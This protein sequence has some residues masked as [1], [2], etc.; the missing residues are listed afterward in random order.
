MK[1]SWTPKSSNIAA[2][3]CTD[4]IKKDI[5]GNALRYKTGLFT[6][7]TN[8]VLIPKGVGFSCRSADCLYYKI[9]SG[10][11][12]HLI[13]YIDDLLSSKFIAWDQ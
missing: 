7:E 6:Q 1:F 10:E 2:C 8:L 9:I 11:G 13:V 3:K 4:M 5:N 12:V